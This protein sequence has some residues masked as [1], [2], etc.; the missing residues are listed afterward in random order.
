LLARNNGGKDKQKNAGK[1][2]YPEHLA[3]FDA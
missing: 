3:A 2:A 1:P